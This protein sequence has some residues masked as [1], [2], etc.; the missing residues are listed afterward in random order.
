MYSVGFIGIRDQLSASYVFCHDGKNPAKEFDAADRLLIHPCYWMALNITRSTT[1]S[2]VITEIHDEYEV[3]VFSEAPEIRK[4]RISQLIGAIDKIEVG[5]E[6]ASAYED[7]CLRV[8]RISF[9]G[10]LGNIELHPNKD[11][12]QRRDILATNLAEKGVWRRVLDDY[13]SRQ[14]VFEVKNKHGIDPDEFRQM[15]TYLHDSYGRIGFIITRDK[16]WNL[17]S[18]PELNWV[19]EIYRTQHKLI[20]KLSGRYFVSLLSKLRGERRRDPAEDALL[21]TLDTYL[22]NYLEDARL[23]VRTQNR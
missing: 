6:G 7:W 20:V 3:E 10:P 9:S 1:R 15:A 2:D 17:F 14:V 23:S 18:G 13:G 21:K 5:P 4:K 12:T 19:R 8:L 11:S 22:R 16:D